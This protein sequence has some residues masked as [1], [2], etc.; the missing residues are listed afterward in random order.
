MIYCGYQGIGKSTLGGKFNIIDLESGNFWVNNVRVNEWYAIYAN[1]A[2]H[3]SNQGFIVF[4]ASHKIFR[5]YLNEQGIE[6][7]TISP[8][9]DL[10][11]EWIKRLEERYNITKLDKD[12]K[13]LMNAKEKYEENV[14]DL[15]SEKN[16]LII[17]RMDYSL[18]DML[19]KN[20]KS[21]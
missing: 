12:Y 9:V 4:T 19:I 1:M 6:F 5:D 2:Q 10:K 20:K 18:L 13:A 7:T 8:S 16:A 3:L 21:Q 11:D 17:N 15:Q 14:L